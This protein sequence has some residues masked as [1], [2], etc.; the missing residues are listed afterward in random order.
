MNARPRIPKMFDVERRYLRSSPPD[1]P[2]VISCQFAGIGAPA[3][4]M[5]KARIAVAVGSRGIANLREIVSIVIRILR[6]AGAQPFI[7]PA[8]GS[9]GGATP[10]GQ[11]HVLAGYGVTPETM[12]VPFDTRMDVRWIGKSENGI[13]VFFSVAAAEADGIVLINRVKPHTDFT[14]T[15]GSGILKMIA[16]GLGKEKG[17]AIAHAASSR[18]GHEVVIRAVA[19]VALRA[20]PILCGIA[21]LEDQ[22]HDTAELRVLKRESIE[23]EEN[24]LFLRARSLMPSLP[25]DEIDL[26]IVDA[27]GKDLSGTGMDTNVIGRSVNGYSSSLIQAIPAR[28]QIHRIFVR[29]LTQTTNGNAVGI[30][31]ADFA[32][33]PSCEL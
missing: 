23:E 19:R 27:I 28:P 13:D 30:G 21:I 24:T 16:I 29:D 9:H 22:N 5:K 3:E 33:T 25:F 14:G 32:T 8:M 6:D 18:L 11:A 12:A 20:T 17:A 7:V 31:L 10:E 15:L 2:S 1:L 26:L 4:G